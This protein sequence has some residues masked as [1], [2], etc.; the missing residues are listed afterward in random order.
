MSSVFDSEAFAELLDEL[1]GYP[2]INS[3][4]FAELLCGCAEEGAEKENQ[5]NFVPKASKVVSNGNTSVYRAFQERSGC[6]LV[7]CNNTKRHLMILPN[8]TPKPEGFTLGSEL[9]RKR[10]IE[11]NGGVNPN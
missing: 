7:F 3:E 2:S 1:V 4:E 10:C 11:R 8:S 9:Y 5:M 6:K